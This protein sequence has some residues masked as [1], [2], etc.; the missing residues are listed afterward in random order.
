MADESMFDDF[1]GDSDFEVAVRISVPSYQLS[2]ETDSS[3]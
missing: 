3:H 2:E 1:G